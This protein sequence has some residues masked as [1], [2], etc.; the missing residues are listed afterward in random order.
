MK[1]PIAFAVLALAAMPA[2]PAGPTAD[3]MTISCRDKYVR[4]REHQ[5]LADARFAMDS[6]NGKVTLL[7][8]DRVVAFQLSDRTVNKVRRELRDKKEEQDNWFAAAIV[9]A[10]AG[11]VSEFI[12]SSVECRIRDLKDVR[13]QDGRLVF[14][15][16]DGRQIFDDVDVDDSDVCSSFS[17]SDARRF[18]REFRRVKAGY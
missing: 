12:D 4:L 6:R 16:R 1:T 3:A 15:S 11:T 17:D 7:L 9:T 5:D 13:F 18:V 8:S 2:L 10:V 14:I